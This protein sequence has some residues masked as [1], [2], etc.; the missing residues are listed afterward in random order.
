MKGFRTVLAELDRGD[1]VNDV[2]NELSDIVE[3]LE[4]NGKG[5]GELTLKIK[6]RA[7]DGMYF[8]EGE[9]AGKKPKPERKQSLFFFDGGTLSRRNPAQPTLPHVVGQA[10][11]KE[12]EK[13]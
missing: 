7:K 3:A 6:I 13:A 11:Q 10:Q 5:V 12:A 4:G 2:E 9:V 8:V 1:F